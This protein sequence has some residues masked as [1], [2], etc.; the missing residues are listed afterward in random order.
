M[1]RGDDLLADFVKS[2]RV[3]LVEIEAYSV[4]IYG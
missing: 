2:G 3:G 1:V 4:R